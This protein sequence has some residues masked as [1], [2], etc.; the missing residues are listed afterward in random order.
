[1]PR[2]TWIFGFSLFLVSA[3]GGS[4]DAA[5]V[6]TPD[7]DGGDASMSG[8]GGRSEAGAGGNDSGA[9]TTGARGPTDCG[10]LVCTAPA[11]CDESGATPRC[12]CP[13]GYDDENGDGSD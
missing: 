5:S 3:C 10:D 8:A 1:M 13:E 11:V 6:D 7:P 12:A 9:S 2:S 4:D